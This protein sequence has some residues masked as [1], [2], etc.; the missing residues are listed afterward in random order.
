MVLF[1]KDPKI[2]IILITIPKY[3]HLLISL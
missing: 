1:L 2:L 3:H